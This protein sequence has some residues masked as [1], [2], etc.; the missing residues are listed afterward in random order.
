MDQVLHP[1]ISGAAL[2]S[3]TFAR[4][5]IAYQLLGAPAGLIGTAHRI[6]GR[7][8]ADAGLAGPSVLSSCEIYVLSSAYR[9]FDD[10][11]NR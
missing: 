4:T 2:V 10:V 9:I 8:D 7:A 11:R 6:Q 3:G 5:K 1:S